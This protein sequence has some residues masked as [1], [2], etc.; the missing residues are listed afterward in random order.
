MARIDSIAALEALYPPASENSLR[1]VA[2]S[3]TPT[4]RAWIAA[5]RFCLVSTVGP[6]GTDCSPRGDRG[7]VVQMRGDRTLLLPDWPGNNRIDSLRNIVRDP[8]VSLLFMVPGAQ[9]VVRVNG[10]AEI[11]TD[12]DDLAP[13]ADGP[14]LPRSAVVITLDE[15]YVQCSKAVIRA[16]LWR[17][18]DDSAQV[19]TLGEMIAEA[20]DGAV[21]AGRFD[22]EFPDRAAR[23]LW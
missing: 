14:R 10:T 8:R 21:E 5:S 23:T 13:F 20:S 11:S 15:V 7:P 3:L 19:P 16:G 12:A 22:A 1:K 9:T 18:E 17:G 6:E 2:H 4:Y